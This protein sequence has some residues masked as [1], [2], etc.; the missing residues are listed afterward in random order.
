M[1]RP[2][3]RR[4]FAP[5]V[6]DQLEQELAL[7]RDLLIAEVGSVQVGVLRFD[8]SGAE[9]TVSVYLDPDLTGLGLGRRVLEAGRRR[10]ASTSPSVATLIADIL[11]ANVASAGTFEQAGYARCSARWTRGVS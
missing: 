4:L 2:L 9:A 10:L 3:F 11:P 1:N 8:R 7:H 6:R 5:P